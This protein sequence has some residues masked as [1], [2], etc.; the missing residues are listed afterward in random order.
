MG[1]KQPKGQAGQAFR[2]G[3]LSDPSP[4]HA[5]H[6]SVP[7][8]VPPPAPEPEKPKYPFRCEDR[9]AIP[10]DLV[11]GPFEEF[12]IATDVYST[13]YLI[14]RN[15]GEMYSIWPW[16]NRDVLI[17]WVFLLFISGSQLF[18]ILS[19][20][21]WYP[22]SVSTESRLTICSNSTSVGDA[23]SEGFLSD[24]S[25]TACLEAG[26]FSFEADVRGIPMRHYPL[27][28][29]TPYFDS[30]LKEGNATIYVL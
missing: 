26:K 5:A 2:T 10:D 11:E 20:T 15:S 29:S 21:F 22:P 25:E 4:A 30:I 3:R 9:S 16:K 18:V 19:V 13:A 14:A 12:E 17:V 7:S 27:E 6:A 8:A 1:Q 24:P 23:F 28:R